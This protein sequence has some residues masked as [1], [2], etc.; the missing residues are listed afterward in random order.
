M[1]RGKSSHTLW[2]QE[3][4]I[5]VTNKLDLYWP[6]TLRQIYY[7]LVAAG[8]IKNSQNAYKA[9]S[10]LITNMRKEGLLSWS[11]MEDRTRRV[12][13]KRGF[14][15][16]SEYIRFQLD[17]FM[18]GYSRCLVQQ[19]ENYV[20]LW[21]E[22]DALSRIFEDVAWPYCVRV[23]TCKGQIST[24]FLKKYFDRSLAEAKK[25]KKPVVIYGGD[26][27]P[28]GVQIPAS[29]ERVLRED[30]GLKV[31]FDR[32]AL[33]REQ[34]DQYTLPHNPDA[35]KWTDPNAKRYAK[36]YGELAVELDALDP[37]VLQD[38]IRTT[39]SKH[40]DIESMDAEASIE[41]KERMEIKHLRQ[42]VISFIEGRGY[43]I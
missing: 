28:S 9:L 34:V 23:V 3:K 10:R 36:I 27:D 43:A 19:Q 4:V 17:T 15:D 38:E 24:T 12:S 40:L 26:L 16:M 2:L 8:Y 22:K 11:C 7:R 18:K 13:A 30:F 5:E 14:H 25:G 41:E 31:T 1:A 29:A 6:L 37:A 21:V 20:E 35:L 39:L 33:T 32:F 42:D